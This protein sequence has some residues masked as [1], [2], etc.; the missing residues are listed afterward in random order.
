[1]IIVLD[2]EIYPNTKYSNNAKVQKHIKYKEKKITSNKILIE[3]SYFQNYHYIRMICATFIITFH[4][5]LSF[6]YRTILQ[7]IFFVRF[8][9]HS[10]R[11]S[12]RFYC[13]PSHVQTVSSRNSIAF[14]AAHKYDCTREVFRWD[15]FGFF[16]LFISDKSLACDNFVSRKVFVPHVQLPVLSRSFAH[17][18][19]HS[20]PSDSPSVATCPSSLRVWLVFMGE[21][22]RAV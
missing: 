6:F 3:K 9:F 4:F 8:F 18:R 11:V 15:P 14:R 21:V 5:L 7:Q 12:G 2:T 22:T 19:S 20:L 16:H 1:M 17:Y 13:Q 10:Q